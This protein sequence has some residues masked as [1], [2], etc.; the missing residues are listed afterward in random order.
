MSSSASQDTGTFSSPLILAFLAIGLFSIA[1]TFIF[2]RRIQ[3]NSGWRLTASDDIN[4][5]FF[6]LPIIDVDIPK[7]WDLSNAGSF[8]REKGGVDT[9]ADVRWANVM[10]YIYAFQHFSH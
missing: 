10:V 8:N 7:L 9:E 4:R 2:W 6:D 3:A 5:S 1:M